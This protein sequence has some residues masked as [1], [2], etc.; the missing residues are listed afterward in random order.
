MTQENR[1]QETQTPAHDSDELPAAALALVVGGVMPPGAPATIPGA[2]GCD[3]TGPRKER[4]HDAGNQ[5]P[6][7]S[8]PDAG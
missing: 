6:G 1:T 5:N 4:R 7:D 2:L 8:Y 3:G